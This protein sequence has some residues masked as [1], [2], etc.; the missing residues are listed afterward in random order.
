[1]TYVWRNLTQEDLDRAYNQAD[2]APNRQ[3]ILDRY[4]VNSADMRRR[5]GEPET[6]RYGTR[7]KEHIDFHRAIGIE[8]GG[9][10]APAVIFVHG[11]AW[12]SGLARNYGYLAEIFVRAG[13]HCLLPEFDWVQDCGGDL[14]PMADQVGRAI[15]HICGNAA[16]L[17]ID[18]EN[19]YLC[20]HSSGSHLAASVLTGYRDRIPGLDPDCIR[21]ALLC[22]GMYDLEPVRLSARSQYVAFTDEAEELLSPMRHLDRL[23][24]PL[25]LAYGTLETPEFQRQTAEFAETLAQRGH[26]VDLLVGEQC[27][28][29]E[30]LETMA[31]PYGLLGR[32]ALEMIGRG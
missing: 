18:P 1:M 21:A 9:G 25:V 19:I 10:S 28:H 27:N 13:A 3:Q 30:I 17:G 6:L 8:P 7:D 11:G 23:A 16:A 15:A 24:M 31:N 2:Y 4:A 12:R 5:I 32:A 20:A 22:S 29:F 26:P 14:L